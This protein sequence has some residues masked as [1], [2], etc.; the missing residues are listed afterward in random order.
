M[1]AGGS[2]VKTTAASFVP[3]LLVPVFLAVFARA[4]TIHVPGDQ[5]TI[6]AGI[7][8]AASGDVVIIACGTYLE[9]PIT[10]KGGITL[11]SET[12][13]PTC[14]TID[15]EG[16]GSIL[17]GQFLD[18]P[19]TIEGLTLTRALVSAG[20]GLS[21]ISSEPFQVLKC[22]FLDNTSLGRGGGVW[23]NRT[24][25]TIEDSEFESNDAHLGGGLASHEAP[26][27][28]SGCSFEF[29]RATGPAYA[30]AGYGGGVLVQQGDGSSFSSCSFL[31]NSATKGGSSAYIEGSS[32]SFTDCLVASNSGS[33]W[34][35]G[36]SD[37]SMVRAVFSQNNR[38]IRSFGSNLA[39]DQC[40]FYETSMGVLGAV[41]LE[42]GAADANRTIIQ[43]GGRGFH[44]RS[45]SVVTVA[46]C[47]LFG[48]P[49]RYFFGCT[50]ETTN[51]I[52]ADPLFCDAQG[53]DFTLRQDS[54]CLPGANP[55]LELIGAF[56]IGCGATSAGAVLEPRSWGRIK[57]LYRR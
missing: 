22:R 44:C 38:G 35:T 15:A 41:E 17:F 31:D 33:F 56:G 8:A 32:L 57:A 9:N 24:P 45:P 36:S 3:L 52:L 27:T 7:D 23:C 26:I 18:A 1:H 14:V 20:G 49:S 21:V 50:P 5:P 55:C 2:T 43:F 47:D 6:Q 53:G 30:F 34:I 40:T 29:N 37:V 19:T 51:V 54:P 16:Q 25:L 4:A 10:L 46:C 42:G 11:R 39:L 28:V 48:D 12:G 13:D